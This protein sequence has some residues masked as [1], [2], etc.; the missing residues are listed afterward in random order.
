MW[1]AFPLGRGDRIEAPE[2]EGSSF[3]AT[4][5]SSDGAWALLPGAGSV[6]FA[7]RVRVEGVPPSSAPPEGVLLSN[8]GPAPADGPLVSRTYPV[9]DLLFPVA[10][11]RGWTALLAPRDYV[12]PEPPDVP[13]SAPP[14]PPTSLTEIL[15]RAAWPGTWDHSG[16]ALDVS[17]RGVKAVTDEARQAEVA[18][19]LERLRAVRRPSTSVRTRVVALPWASLPEWWT[20]LPEDLAKDDGAALLARAGA[21]VVEDVRL[22]LLDGQR[23]AA[24]TGARHTYVAGYS[25]EIADKSVIGK[26]IVTSLFEGS[27]LDLEGDPVF[28]APAANLSLRLDAGRVLESRSV[29]TQLGTIEC[30]RFAL[31]RSRGEAT[32]PYGTTRIVA[33]WASGD[34]LR[35]CLVTASRE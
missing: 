18:A 35:L 17:A 20:G 23:R 27:S 10:S 14:F 13:P 6:V 28:G 29:P 9:D 30:P 33:V 16:A 24:V 12:P 3:D 34:E 31:V 2:T 32:V 5:P 1:G 7:A 4:V 21:R 8:S 19:L 22:P 15:R 26:P 25:I 11:S